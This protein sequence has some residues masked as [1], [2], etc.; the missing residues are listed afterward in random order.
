MPPV[1]PEINVV[2]GHAD[3][4]PLEIS[5]KRCVA[6]SQLNHPN[7]LAVYDSGVYGNVPY[8][9]CELL[10]GE[11]LRSRLDAG[12]PTV[13]TTIEYACQIAEGLAA[14]HDRSIIHRD[15]KPDNLFVTEESR[16]KILDFGLAKLL[17]PT[18]DDATG[19]VHET[20][21]GLILGT[22]SYMSPEQVR[23]ESLD[24]RSDIFSFGIILRE[25]LTG[26]QPFDR[27]TTADTMAAIL[28]EEPSGELPSTVSPA[29]ERI[30]SRC[31]E[32][33]REAR[34]QSARDLA[35]GLRFLSGPGAGFSAASQQSRPGWWKQRVLPWA[36]TGTLAIAFG[37]V[38]ARFAP[39]KSTPL[40]E[41]L[42]LTPVLT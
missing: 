8:I 38:V 35:F 10:E 6:T 40:R 12:M 7:I 27:G 25:M 15:L 37:V 3:R 33:A 34:F 42:R 19:M 31:L 41:P 9:V 23:G 17:Q 26:R 21:P 36:V 30:A 20:E 2:A 11:S 16:L 14:A 4:K 29:L 28:K 24:V 1:Q 22:V 32:K 39:W 18:E 5:E 13:R